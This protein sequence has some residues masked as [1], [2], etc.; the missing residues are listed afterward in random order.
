MYKF[1]YFLHKSLKEMDE[2]A[3]YYEMSIAAN[4]TPGNL[5]AYSKFFLE[6]KVADG[7]HHSIRFS[8]NPHSYVMHLFFRY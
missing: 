8:D 5:I 1:A 7:H 4:K 2:A 6:Q 3:T